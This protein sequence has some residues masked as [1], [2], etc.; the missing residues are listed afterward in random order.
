MGESVKKYRTNK[1][2]NAL[3][4]QH[5][6]SIKSN[7]FTAEELRN[8]AILAS[9]IVEKENSFNIEKKTPLTKHE[10]LTALLE[11]SELIET[12]YADRL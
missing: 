10:Q 2:F 1:R 5:I 6:V 12:N 7:N 4:Q 3:V 8:A 11:F 9:V